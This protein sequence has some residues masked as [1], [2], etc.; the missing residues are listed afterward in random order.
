MDNIFS[1]TCE[2]FSEGIWMGMHWD[3]GGTK[4]ETVMIWLLI[5]IHIISAVLDLRNLPDVIGKNQIHALFI[6]SSSYKQLCKS[7]F[8]L[9][10]IFVFLFNN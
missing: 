9:C 10:F 1:I 7:S 2:S 5:Y 4:K 8:L 3:T 6:V